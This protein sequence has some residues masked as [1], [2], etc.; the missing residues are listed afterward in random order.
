MRCLVCHFFVDVVNIVKILLTFI[1]ES[2]CSCFL[3]VYFH[4]NLIKKLF[5]SNKIKFNQQ[6]LLQI[7]FQTQAPLE[8]PCETNIDY[9]GK[10]NISKQYF[11]FYNI[12]SVILLLPLFV[13]SK[14]LFNALLYL[15]KQYTSTYI[16]IHTF[17]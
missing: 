3:M 2:K 10:I 11:T 12:C 17:F 1:S 14:V 6:C 5:V 7:I 4:S 13:I 16:Y 8:W 15:V 9:Q